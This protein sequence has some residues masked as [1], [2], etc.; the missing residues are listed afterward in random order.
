MLTNRTNKI[1]WH[2]TAVLVIYNLVAPNYNCPWELSYS[3]L[4]QLPKYTLFAPSSPPPPPPFPHTPP[5]ICTTFVFNFSW[6]LQVV[7]REIDDNAYAKFLGA[8]KVYYGR[9]ANCESATIRRLP[10]ST[11]LSGFSSQETY[12]F[13][14]SADGEHLHFVSHEKHTANTS[15]TFPNKM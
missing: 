5:K 9:C 11:F 14:E 12:H 3:L 8:N 6:V 7:P 1:C 4:A 2:V 10:C 15:Y 13:W